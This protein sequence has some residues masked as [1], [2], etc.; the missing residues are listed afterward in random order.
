MPGYRLR[1]V[2]EQGADVKSG[3]IGEL[4]VEG[5]SAAAC[6]WNQREKSR[7]TFEG[8]WTRT[9]DKYEQRADGRFVYCGRTDDMFKVSGIWVSPFEVEGALVSHPDV[10]E[11]A[12]VAA[13]DAEGLDKPKAFVVLQSGTGSETLKETLKAHVKDKVGKWKYPR[14]IEIVDDLPKTATGKIQRFRLRTD[15][16]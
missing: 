7:R 9:G 15:V 16:S 3:E 11:A 6:Y 12:V 4:L 10:L 14:W 5:A 13:Q 2:D 1:L 8:V